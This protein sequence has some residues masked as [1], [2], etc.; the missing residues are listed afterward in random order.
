MSRRILTCLPSLLLVGLL[1]PQG[2]SALGQGKAQPKPPQWTHAFDLKCRNS[3]QPIFDKD[4]KTFGM[5]VFRDDN[6]G[7]GVYILETGVLSVVRGFANVPAPIKDSKSPEWMHGLDLKVR[8]ANE[9][10]FTDK[11]QVFGIEIFRDEN[12]GN[13][14][15]ITEKGY[16][17]VAPGDK[18]A[19]A[20]T[21]S[22]KAPVWVHGL[23]LKV[24]KAG[25]KGFDN[26]TKVYSVEV[27]RD[28][29]TGLLMYVSEVGAIAV[30]PGEGPSAGAKSKAP[31]WMH[32]LDL[33]CRRGGERE[34]EAK[35]TKTFGMEVFRDENTGNWLYICETGTLAVLPGNK[36][37]KAPTPS[38]R[39]PEWTHG[40]DLKVRKF[41]EPE[42]GPNT[43]VFGVEI[44]RDDNTGSIVYIS[45]VGSIT[46]AP[47]K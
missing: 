32:G 28:E 45:E 19:R 36:T 10:E 25:E 2:P 29:N 42:F 46:A 27:F 21:P 33:K 17:A 47:V 16:V 7:N 23:D 38:P 9:P 34:F 14:I 22:P 20:P 12:T 43:R 35:S 13:W 3:K 18:G 39:Q 37:A 1:L 11:T 6:N 31:E 15:Y 30:V 4:T 40:L 44:F 5:E 24:R 41:G 26:N 8:K